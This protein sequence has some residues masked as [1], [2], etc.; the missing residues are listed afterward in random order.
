MSTIPRYPCVLRRPSL[1]AEQ[2]P[3]L[4]A[5]SFPSWHQL[6]HLFRG[7]CVSLNQP[8]YHVHK[9]RFGRRGLRCCQ[10]SF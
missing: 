9:D 5:T 4:P 8:R 6:G 10:S 7:H 2:V 1:G 3:A